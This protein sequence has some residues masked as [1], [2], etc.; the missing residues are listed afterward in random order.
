VRKV[1]L[2]KSCA[3]ENFNNIFVNFKK[4]NSL[5]NYEMDVILSKI[6][7]AINVYNLKI[8]Y[9]QSITYHLASNLTLVLL[10]IYAI[11]IISLSNGKKKFNFFWLL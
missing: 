6:G 11:I 3:I 9:R 8:D 5:L 1:V 7:L 2:D 10:Q 4:N